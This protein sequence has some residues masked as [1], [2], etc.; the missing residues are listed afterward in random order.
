MM[1][2]SLDNLAALP[3]QTKVYCAHEY[4]LANLAFARAVEPDNSALQT[5]IT[6]AEQTRERGDP[7][8]PSDIALEL[9][10]NPFLRCREA[11]LQASLVSQGR[12]ETGEN[13]SPVAIFANVRG[14]KDNF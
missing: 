6:A 2:N 7:T 8:V 10:T 13:D 14:W 5:R 3:P 12:L 1:L 4:T 11:S 9:A